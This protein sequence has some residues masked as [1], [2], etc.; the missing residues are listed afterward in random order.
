MII[1][2]HHIDEAVA[3]FEASP[4]LFVTET[5]AYLTRVPNVMQYIYSDNFTM[6]TPNEKELFEYLAYII[7]K[8]NMLARGEE[9]EDPDPDTIA[10]L[11]ERHWEWI[12][13]SKQKE[14][15]DKITPFFEEYDE[16]EALAFIEDSL[17]DDTDF[18]L[19]NE[20]KSLFFVGLST[21][22]ISFLGH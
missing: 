12:Q 2:I 21:I 19:V 20:V 8:S 14:F 6:F 4:E 15:R 5:E 9:C 1:Q 18:N 11:E 7:I 10:G 22:V 17:V 16:E 13:S 3:Y